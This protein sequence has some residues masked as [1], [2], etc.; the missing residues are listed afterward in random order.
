MFKT[1]V[2][3]MEDS[4]SVAYLR[5]ETAQGI[6]ANF[7]NVLDTTRIRVPFGIAQVGKS[8]RNEIN[9]RNFTFRSREFE[10]MEI[11]FF[12]HESTADA[13]YEY[14][15]DA[16]YQW[17]VRHGLK[18]SKLHLRNHEKEELAHY[19]RACADVEYEFPF[20]TAEL[21][22]VANRTDFD[23]KAHQTASGRDMTFYNDETKER[24]I[25]FVIE[26]SGGVDRATL[27]FL[28]EAY[29]EDEAPDE[30]GKP[31]K[32]VVLKFH[33][34]LAPIKVAVKKDGMPEKAQ[35]ICDAL[36]PHMTALYDEKGAVGR[37]YRRQDEAGTPFCITVDGQTHTDG[38]V[39]IR[40]RDS[41]K[42]ERIPGDPKALVAY[43]WERLRS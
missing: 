36:R 15:R 39:T 12:C 18:S 42:Q 32:R 26:P 40:D 43:F 37:R 9:P 3:A 22:G 28:C 23:L 6:F 14:W 20:G 16:R 21:E 31:Q 24:F 38:T 2:G 1:F 7:K 27:A 11:E 5:P 41:M 4:A 33:P 30:Q 10:Q 17:Y 19:A 35:A 25:P 34:R 29:C 13:W 8:F